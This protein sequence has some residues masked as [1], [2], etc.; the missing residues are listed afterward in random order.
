LNILD[1]L[2]VITIILQAYKWGSLGF[3]SSFFA[4]A[5]TISG[6]ML[7]FALAPLVIVFFED[8]IFRLL[9]SLLIVVILVVLLGTIGRIIGGKLKELVTKI[10]L[11]PVDSALGAAFS[12]LA[13]TV[14]LWLALSAFSSSP[15]P[16]VNQQIRDSRIIQAVDNQLPPAPAIIS[17]FSRYINQSIFP[18]VFT[19]IEPRPVEPVDPPTDSDL[20]Q[21]AQA[22]QNSVARVESLACG[23]LL[24]GSG[25]FVTGNRVVTN[26]HVV[27][28]S[29]Q[30]SVTTTSGSYRT[31]VIYFDP[32]NDIAVLYAPEAEISP[33]SLVD[34]T[35]P[36]GTTGATLGFPR[37]EDLT[38][39]PAA[40]LRD[41]E[42][43]GRDI[44]GRNTVTRN[45]YELQTSVVSGNSGGPV[46]LPNGDVF[47]VIFAKSETNT[48]TGYAIP[49]NLVIESL[50]ATTNSTEPINTGSCVR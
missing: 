8:E 46:V 49:S 31:E 11:Q 4:L 5:G 43:R 3:F 20:N 39:G 42:A 23:G 30:P 28:G 36:R 9:A 14:F 10:K 26:A 12:I 33:L 18:Q 47:A 48:N 19:G 13:T 2:I 24:S 6:L 17:G 44:Y 16:S 22:S 32:D 21:A 34:Q 50:R 35:L 1:F 41:L 25:F 37:G 45:V 7:S 38:I 40:I 29:S 15:F 27:A